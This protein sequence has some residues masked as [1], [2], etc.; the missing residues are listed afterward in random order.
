MA[1]KKKPPGLTA[2]TVDGII[3]RLDEHQWVRLQSIWSR[4]AGEIV[5]AF[6]DANP[7][8]F[9]GK[10]DPRDWLPELLTSNICWYEGP[11]PYRFGDNPVADPSINPAN[12]SADPANRIPMFVIA[13]VSREG[14]I[15]IRVRRKKLIRHKTHVETIL[16]GEEIYRRLQAIPRNARYGLKAAFAREKGVERQTVR[17]WLIAYC[18]KSGKP[19]L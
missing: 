15:A 17:Q 2:E 12:P 1:K 3:T 11:L 16:N 6:L 9:E 10:G 8:I 18:E 7:W 4:R 19:Y 5:M 13:M 14:H